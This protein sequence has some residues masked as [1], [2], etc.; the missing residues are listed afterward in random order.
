VPWFN[1]ILSFSFFKYKFQSEP[2]Y[3][4]SCPDLDSRDV[5]NFKDNT[6][7]RIVFAR[8]S[9]GAVCIEKHGRG[10]S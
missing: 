7:N 8:F 9:L 4:G 6:Q 10:A 1:L 5:N 3:S 2:S